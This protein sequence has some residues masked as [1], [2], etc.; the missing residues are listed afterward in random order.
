MPAVDTTTTPPPTA[1]DRTPPPPASTSVVPSRATRTTSTSSG[2]VDARTTTAPS[3]S[4]PTTERTCSPSGDTAAPSTTNRLVPALDST[5]TMAP[6]TRRGAPDTRSTQ[7]SSTRQ[8]RSMVAPVSGSTSRKTSV[9]WS[10]VWATTVGGPS[11]GHATSARYSNLPS[12]CQ[13]TSVVVPS[14]STTARPTAALTEPAAGYRM[15]RGASVGST[16]DEIHHSETPAV[17]TRATSNRLPS[18]D[19]QW[20]RVRPISSA[21]MYSADPHDTVGVDPPI[22]RRSP[23]VPVTRSDEP[24]TYATAAPSGL[25]RGSK[26]SPVEGSS[27]T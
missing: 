3:P 18:G 4:I 23:P 13:S 2:S 22:R 10:R 1:A 19:H 21:A 8:V 24:D 15:A 6:S 9:F 27:T 16:G 12:T 25:S 11:A 14:R 17:S 5:V 7:R 20:P 26:A